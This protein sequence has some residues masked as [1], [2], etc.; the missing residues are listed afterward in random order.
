MFLIAHTAK[1]PM[2]GPADYARAMMA[3][4]EPPTDRTAE[5]KAAYTKLQ[6]RIDAYVANERSTDQASP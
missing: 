3:L 5:E 6:A 2:Q 1:R 4:A